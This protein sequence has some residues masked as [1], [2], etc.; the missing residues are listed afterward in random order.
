MVE[1]LKELMRNSF[2][3]LPNIEALTGLTFKGYL[4]GY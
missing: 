2:F 4:G 1:A 3:L